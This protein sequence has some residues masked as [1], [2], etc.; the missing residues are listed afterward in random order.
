MVATACSPPGRGPS[1]RDVEEQPAEDAPGHD[2]VDELEV[3]AV[4]LL[5]DLP[6]AELRVLLVPQ[7]RIQESP[8]TE[9]YDG[10]P[11]TRA[12]QGPAGRQQF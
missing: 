6:L 12:S 3:P 4:A 5:D 10:F 8:W 7:R 2:E 9:S 11:M 1:P